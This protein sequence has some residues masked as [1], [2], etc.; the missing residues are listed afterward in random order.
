M[1]SRTLA[2]LS[3]S[4]LTSAATD[5]ICV[6]AG[7]ECSL[8]SQ[9]VVAPGRLVH[10]AHSVLRSV[11]PL[12]ELPIA[13]AGL[14]RADARAWNWMGDAIAYRAKQSPID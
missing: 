14:G 1:N 5:V 7:G 3:T 2:W 13:N 6:A 12:L 4:S 10:Q 8:K 11:M 9:S